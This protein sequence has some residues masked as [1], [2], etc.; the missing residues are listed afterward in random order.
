MYHDQTIEICKNLGARVVH[1]SWLGYVKQKQFGLNECEH[2]W[3]L[4][5]DADEIAP[6][7]CAPKS[8]CAYLRNQSTWATMS[9]ELYSLWVLGWRKGGWYP[10]FRLRLMRRSLT[11]WGGVDPHERAFVAGP[12]GK[13]QG[14]ILH[15]SYQNINDQSSV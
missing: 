14:E 13:L 5:I 2:E 10:E 9:H 15:Y 3:V 12:I 11:S 6:R 7:A 1:S 8:N 4:N